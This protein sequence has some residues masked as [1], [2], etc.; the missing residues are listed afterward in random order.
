MILLNL[1]DGREGG[2]AAAVLLTRDRG[3]DNIRVIIMWTSD[4]QEGMSR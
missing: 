2:A 3:R 4:R 1:V